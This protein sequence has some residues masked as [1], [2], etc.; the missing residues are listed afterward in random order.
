MVVPHEFWNTT[1]LK[2]HVKLRK[3]INFSQQVLF[4]PK[5]LHQKE[6]SDTKKLLLNKQKSNLLLLVLKTFGV[7][8]GNN[9]HGP[10]LICIHHLH[11]PCQSFHHLLQVLLVAFLL[12]WLEIWFLSQIFFHNRN[13][14][15][16]LQVKHL[17]TGKLHCKIIHCLW[18]IFMDIWQILC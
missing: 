13:I 18:D 17:S 5:I 11:I 10:S 12:L 6:S 16:Y 1:F 7:E 2:V 9:R 8:S 3:Q 15:K 4:R 14:P